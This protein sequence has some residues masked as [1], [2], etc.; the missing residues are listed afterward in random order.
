MPRLPLRVWLATS[1]SLISSLRISLLSTSRAIDLQAYKELGLISHFISIEHAHLDDIV[2]STVGESQTQR[3]G[4]KLRPLCYN[5]LTF[6]LPKTADDARRQSIELS[7]DLDSDIV[8]HEEG[9]ELADVLL[10]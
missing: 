4:R 6:N 10:E 5:S 8:L 1:S 9:S 2:S 3:P 7:D